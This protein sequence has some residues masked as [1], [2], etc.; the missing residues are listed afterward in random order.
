MVFIGIHD[1]YITHN[2]ILPEL[3]NLDQAKQIEKNVKQFYDSVKQNNTIWY[4]KVQPYDEKLV[5]NI[6]R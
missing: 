2:C 1:Y 4:Q 5:I 3:N 6:I